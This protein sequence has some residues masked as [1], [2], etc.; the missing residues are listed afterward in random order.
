MSAGGKRVYGARRRP[1]I[2]SGGLGKGS[3]P[4]RDFEIQLRATGVGGW[5]REYRFAAPRRWRFDF[6]WSA[7][8]LAVEI[9]GGVWSSG[10][11]TR[12]AGFEAD[13]EKYAVATVLG[14]RVLRVTPTHVR[15]GRALGW[16]EACLDAGRGAIA[17]VAAG[18]ADQEATVD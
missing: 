8:K 14:W 13:C 12:G 11:H 7:V 10:R 3:A 16:V 6:A 9:E 17:V 5:E 15:D 18:R 4:E 1:R 2:V